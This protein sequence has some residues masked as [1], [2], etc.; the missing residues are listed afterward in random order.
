M[1]KG[2]VIKQG[3]KFIA[4]TKGNKR[5]PLKYNTKGLAINA[6]INHEKEVQDKVIEQAKEESEKR[7]VAKDIESRTKGTVDTKK[8]KVKPKKKIVTKEDK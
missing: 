3:N 1:V 5:L 7:K 4:V 8:I 6:L 2:R